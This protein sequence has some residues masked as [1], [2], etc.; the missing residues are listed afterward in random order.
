MTDSLPPPRIDLLI[1]SPTPSALLPV[2][3]ILLEPSPPL[4]LLL[5]PQLHAT[6]VDS[7]P[8]SYAQLLQQ[9]QQLVNKWDVTDQAKFL[10]SHPRIGETINLSSSSALEQQPTGRASPTP[11][12][13]LKRLSVSWYRLQKLIVWTRGRAT[14]EL[15]LSAQRVDSIASPHAGIAVAPRAALAAGVVNMHLISLSP[16]LSRTPSPFLALAL[17]LPSSSKPFG[18]RSELTHLRLALLLCILTDAQRSLRGGLPRSALRHIRQWP[19]EGRH[20]S[21]DAGEPSLFFQW[22]VNIGGGSSCTC[23]CLPLLC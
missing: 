13:V 23:I 12:E 14:A 11:G 5:A 4:N 15:R 10:A 18:A 21:R 3:N 8:S 16:L 9:A 20:H 7:P 1:H 19:P 2:L 17:T 6:F 22:V